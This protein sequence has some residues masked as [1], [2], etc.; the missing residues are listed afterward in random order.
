LSFTK[1]TTL[2][3][4]INFEGKTYSDTPVPGALIMQV[5]YSKE[6]HFE[7][8]YKEHYK[9]L[10][11]YAF[12]MLKDSENAEEM[13]QQVFL[14]L[15]ETNGLEHINESVPGYLYRAVH[16]ACLN[17]LKHLKVKH[18]YQTYAVTRQEFASATETMQ[19]R[20]L[21]V[22]LNDALNDLPEQCRTIFQMSRFEHLKYH[23]IADRLGLSVKTVE[24]QIGKALKILRSKLA[25]YLPALLIT[26]LLNGL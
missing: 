20:E 11:A 13:V 18:A 4:A 22:K 1:I 24:N 10:H 25:D 7:Q 2:V 12:V 17:F 26:F 19:M 15:W 8:V 16:N 21:Q 6:A 9:R 23:E 3:K 5:F 14:K